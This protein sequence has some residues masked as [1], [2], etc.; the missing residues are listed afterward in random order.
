MSTPM[1]LLCTL[2]FII[3]IKKSVS[4]T[5]SMDFLGFVV[6]ST[7][8]IISLLKQ[9][10]TTLCKTAN[11]LFKQEKVTARQLAQLV[12]M[13]VAAHPAILLAPLHFRTLARANQ[14]ALRDQA[15]YKSEVRLD[16][17]MVQDL[18]WWAN[19]AA[20]FNGR[21]LQIYN[22]DLIIEPDASLTGWGAASQGRSKGGP[23]MV[24]S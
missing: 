2:G 20:S 3:N 8:M 14:K 10:L 13:M 17:E 5:R 12:G 16:K 9:K 18:E 7:T 15:G 21:P 4:P 1:E 19:L 11:Q 24:V 6:D 22:W 23:W